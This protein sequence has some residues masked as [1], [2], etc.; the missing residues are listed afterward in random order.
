M[1]LTSVQLPQKR[2]KPN[3]A[4]L[5]QELLGRLDADKRDSVLVWD[6]ALAAGA[7]DSQVIA[8][9]TTWLHREKRFEDA[10][11]GLLAAI[12]NGL[13]EPWMYDVLA[14]EMK[15]A[16]RPQKQIDRVLLS[17]IDFAAGDD[18]QMLVAASNLAAFDAFKESIGL[19]KELAKRNP[20]QPELWSTARR[21]A[22]LDGDFE[23]RTWARVQTLRNVWEPGFETL[24][25]QMEAELQDLVKEALQST[26][27]RAA[28]EIREALRDAVR[29]DLRVQIEWIG[30]GDVDLS[31][32]EPNG[33]TCSRRQKVTANGGLLVK[34]DLAA[35]PSSKRQ[36]EEYICVDAKPGTY[37]VKVEH[38]DGRVL[39][40]RV[41]VK[42]TRNA[43]TDSEVT[44]T[45]SLTGVVEA[46]Q[47]FD[48]QYRD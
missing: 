17:R 37:T 30:D 10:V 11:E 3:A 39:L 12:R 19:C 24:H 28:S 47:T 1:F 13:A 25:K 5:S 32:T 29:R 31:I 27:S 46:A 15:L 35:R 23:L 6:D 44:E 40:G 42:V 36:I 4:K 45:K 7:Y 9:V 43:G 16:K 33:L 18:A 26:N 21:V 20:H 41:Q 8:I 22:D 2:G 38:M 14:V 48:F 34:Q